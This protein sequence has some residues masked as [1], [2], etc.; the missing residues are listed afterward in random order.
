[1]QLPGETRGATLIIDAVAMVI[2][3]GPPPK[4]LQTFGEFSMHFCKS[5]LHTG[6][7]SDHIDVIFD[8][9]YQESVKAGTR[10]RQKQGTAVRRVMHTTVPLPAEWKGFLS[11]PKNKADLCRLLAATLIEQAPQ[12]K[13]VVA[14]G[15]CQDETLVLSNNNDVNLEFLKAHHEEAGTRLVLH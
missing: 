4:S 7:Q 6:S 1:M 8:R 5:V 10:I 2:S 15:G 11:V 9:Y 3:L 13:V 14:A 12:D